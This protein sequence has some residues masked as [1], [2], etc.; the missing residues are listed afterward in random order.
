MGDQLLEVDLS[1]QSA[2]DA[3][4]I[5]WAI[6]NLHLDLEIGA[7]SLRLRDTPVIREFLRRLGV[8]WREITAELHPLQITSEAGAHRHHH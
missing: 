5:G 3:A 1:N 2:Q 6:G 7:Q 4:R 8:T